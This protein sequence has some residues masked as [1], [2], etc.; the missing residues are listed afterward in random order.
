MDLIIKVIVT[1]MTVVALTV[2]FFRLL[3]HLI[4]FATFHKRLDSDNNCRKIDRNKFHNLKSRVIKIKSDKNYLFGEMFCCRKNEYK[5]KG[6]IILVHGHKLFYLDYLHEI[7]YFCE[8]GYLVYA[9][10]T[11]G[12]GFSSGNKI[13][14]HPTWFIDLHNVICYFEKNEEFNIYDL[15]LFGHS[16]GGYAVTTVLNFNHRKVKAVVACSPI[17]SGFNFGYTVWK[18]HQNFITK[19]LYISMLKHEYKRFEELALYSA[20]DGIMKSK[21]PTLIIH[22]KYDKVVPLNYSLYQIK[23]EFRTQKNVEFYL[24]DT[25]SHFV[26]KEGV[27][28]EILS[29]FFSRYKRPYEYNIDLQIMDRIVSHYDLYCERID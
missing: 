8:K 2:G 26:F 13:S 24:K 1:A 28:Y 10:D 23:D 3:G 21:I 6:I 7:N 18:N 4:L 16:M 27:K 17:N 14:G 11:S 22:G 19:Q 5:Y 20:K 25:T 9:Y 15:F 29:S 12:C